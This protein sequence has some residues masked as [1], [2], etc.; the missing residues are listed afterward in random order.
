MFVEEIFKD[1]FKI[2]FNK[3]L[4]HRG[5]FS[6]TWSKSKFKKIDLDI[7]FVQDNLSF[8]VK[9]YTLRGL[10]Y[11]KPPFA[12]DKLVIVLKGKILDVFVDVRLGSPNFGNWGSQTLNE[13]ENNSL[14]IPKGFLHGFITL[15]SNTLI[16]YKCSNFYHPNYEGIIRYNDPLLNIKWSSKNI[17]FIISDKDKK[18]DFF[19]DFKSPF[20]YN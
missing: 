15:S 16:S 1:V 11:Q 14:L 7:D 10:H 9:K 17:D 5:F 20:N 18:G 13:N 8:N 3:F 2:E 4:D 19:K 6:E 12:Q